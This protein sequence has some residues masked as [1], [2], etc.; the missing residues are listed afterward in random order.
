M[1]TINMA[2]NTGL[3]I[4]FMIACVI[5]ILS[6][7]L[8]SY[9]CTGGT[10]DFDNFEASKCVE[11]P[12]DDNTDPACN[13]FTT[14][15]DCPLTCDWDT[16]TSLCSEPAGGG[17]GNNTPN[18]PSNS[19]NIPRSEH[20]CPGGLV[21]DQSN[22]CFVKGQEKAGATWAWAEY[23]SIKECKTKCAK[24]QVIVYSN[25]DENV[26]KYRYIK[27]GSNSSD[28]AFEGAPANWVTG[29]AVTFEVTPLTADDKKLTD[30]ATIKVT[31]LGESDQCGDMGMSNYVNFN[32]LE[33]LQ[34]GEGDTPPP[35][36]KDCSGG[37][38]VLDEEY[39]CL[40]DGSPVD[41]TALGPS[42][43]Q[44]YD[45]KGDDYIPASGGGTCE[46]IRYELFPRGSDQEYAGDG[47]IDCV[48][49]PWVPEELAGVNDEPYNAVGMN[50]TCSAR[51]GTDGLQRQAKHVMYDDENTMD[52]TSEVCAT[53]IQY[54]ACNRFD[55]G[56]SCEGSL[57][58]RDVAYD[59]ECVIDECGRNCNCSKTKKIK[60]FKASK[61]YR[62]GPLGP[63]NNADAETCAQRYP[64]KI[65]RYIGVWSDGEE[66]DCKCKA[67]GS[68]GCKDNMYEQMYE[69]YP[70][71]YR[72]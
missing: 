22:A 4:V 13:T 10:W 45:K 37:T 60:E 62:S 35:E 50:G 2:D 18:I 27:D 25:Q 28:F 32:D 54:V 23:E 21:M 49:N 63:T 34:E 44:K 19:E 46:E 33:F 55:C 11:I 30:T 59:T 70:G 26:A 36:K 3:F 68:G 31:A 57:V 41:K 24:Y 12:E 9:T 40:V 14:S 65:N 29:R 64:D 71:T 1:Y 47:R 53:Q 42:C 8:M 52:G 6:S 56:R 61:S 17:G 72:R 20:Y 67:C 15:S 58:E 16:T 7:V 5:S 69:L 39:G 51:C 48:F 38:W 43:M 66:A